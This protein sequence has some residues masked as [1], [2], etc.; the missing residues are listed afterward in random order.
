MLRC[1]FARQ[2]YGKG[3]FET[4]RHHIICLVFSFWIWQRL[5]LFLMHRYVH[6]I[7]IVAWHFKTHLGCNAMH[8]LSVNRCHCTH[9]DLCLSRH[10][11][12]CTVKESLFPENHVGV[13]DWAKTCAYVFLFFLPS[14][15]WSLS[16]AIRMLIGLAASQPISFDYFIIKWMYR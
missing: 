10:I 8:C 1:L 12:D 5:T 9:C 3:R 14:C 4:S 13:P 2:K 6:V 16:T 15:V 11:Q 7:F